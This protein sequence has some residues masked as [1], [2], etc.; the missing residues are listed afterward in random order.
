M[1]ALPC[2]PTGSGGARLPSAGVPVWG[3]GTL[4][5]LVFCCVSL[6]THSLLPLCS[7]PFRLQ[8]P[9]VLAPETSFKPQWVPS[10]D[11]LRGTLLEET[12]QPKEEGRKRGGIYPRAEG[13]LG[14]QAIRGRSSG[15][16]QTALKLCL[17]SVCNFKFRI[18]EGQAGKAISFGSQDGVIRTAGPFSQNA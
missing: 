4:G 16:L 8:K 18:P 14:E 11:P 13:S 12:F 1:E 9:S 15:A 2:P 6:P 10:G 3:R 7:L 17:D 5:L